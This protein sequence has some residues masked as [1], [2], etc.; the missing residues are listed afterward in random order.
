MLFSGTGNSA[1]LFRGEGNAVF[2][3]REFSITFSR[4]WPRTYARNCPFLIFTRSFEA[5][6]L[7]L[8]LRQLLLCIIAAGFDIIGTGKRQRPRFLRGAYDLR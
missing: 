8:V 4:K 5:K 1:L 2:R 7:H 3:N 6:R